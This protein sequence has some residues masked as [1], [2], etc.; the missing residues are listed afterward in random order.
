MLTEHA[1]SLDKAVLPSE[2]LLM[3]QT[4][5]QTSQTCSLSRLFARLQDK[6]KDLIALHCILLHFIALHFIALHCIALYFIAL[7]FIALH[8]IALHCI[9]DPHHTDCSYHRPSV[10]R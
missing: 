1:L 3:G 5:S 9:G 4:D 2:F 8:C 6:R 7:Y 10:N